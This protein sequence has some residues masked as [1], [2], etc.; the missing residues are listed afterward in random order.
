MIKHLQDQGFML[1]MHSIDSIT[2]I[3]Q[4]VW[5]SLR[6]QRLTERHNG[7]PVFSPLSLPSTGTGH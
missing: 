3:N 6:A 5:D 1:V 2:P 7:R 4:L